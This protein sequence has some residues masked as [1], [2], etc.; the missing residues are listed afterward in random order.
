MQ[1]LE[2]EVQGFKSLYD[3]KL[4]KLQPINVFHGENNVGKSNLLEAME[5]FFR[6]V[7]V[8]LP[9][10]ERDL[11]FEEFSERFGHGREI[12]S[13]DGDGRIHLRGII[14]LPKPKDPNLP[15]S[16]PAEITI[17]VREIP[18]SRQ[19][20][21]GIGSLKLAGRELVSQAPQPPLPDVFRKFVTTVMRP[22]G[23]YRIRSDRRLTKEMEEPGLT[24]RPAELTPLSPSGDN[25]KQWLF[26]AS[27]STDPGERRAFENVL[28]PLFSEPPLSLGMLR[29]VAAPGRP[30]DLQIETNGQSPFIDQLGSGIQQLALLGGM[31]ALSQS[32]IV[33]IEEPEINLSWPTQEKL[34]HILSNMVRDTANA[35][36]QFF[37]SSHSPLFEF[38]QGFFKVE[39][40][41]GQTR[42]IPV[43]NEARE[44]L[45]FALSEGRGTMLRNGKSVVYE[46]DAIRIRSGNAVVLPDYVLKALGVSQGDAVYF[47]RDG[48][49]VLILNGAQ[50]EELWRPQ[51]GG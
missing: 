31:I 16:S 23:F 24:M 21:V 11:S 25:L 35:P 43:P 1:L 18:G 33:A 45:F 5:L 9:H 29:P 34:K 26:W 15:D 6:V 49:R 50:L 44:E 3:C 4:T 42:V 37:L 38:Y 36:T 2:F 20:R 17:V 39:M 41:D 30:Y 46:R 10:K 27:N 48:D 12:F 7:A 19:V 28:R 14:S 8:L 22:H 47:H 13:W 32:W 51:E 40:V